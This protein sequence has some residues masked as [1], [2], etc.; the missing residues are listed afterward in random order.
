[1][2]RLGVGVGSIEDIKVDQ[3]PTFDRLLMLM[4]PV[5]LLQRAMLDLQGHVQMVSLLLIEVLII[6]K[7]RITH[8]LLL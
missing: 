8:Q 2:S 5:R 7:L 6:F 4:L 1:M 3:R